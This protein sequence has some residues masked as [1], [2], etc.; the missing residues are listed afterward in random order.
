MGNKKRSS[1][2]ST[3][4]IILCF[5]FCWPISVILIIARI[6]E[7]KKEDNYTLYKDLI[8]RKGMRN[9]SEISA[10]TGRLYL[11]VKYEIQEMINRGIL[12]GA[13]IDKASETIVFTAPQKEFQEAYQDEEIL[14]SSPDIQPS[15]TPTQ[16]RCPNC[17]ASQTLINGNGECEYCGTP[18]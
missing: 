6:Q 13:Y 17:G 12:V 16:T 10:E 8:F 2:Y 15:A 9:L 1:L 14:T 3:P 5:L 4:F 7:S 18:L 11:I